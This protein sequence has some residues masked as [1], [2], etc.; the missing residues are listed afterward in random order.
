LGGTG[1]IRKNGTGTLTLSN[2]NYF[3]GG[4]TVSIGALVATNNTPQASNGIIT[5]GDANTAR[6]ITNLTSGYSVGGAFASNIVVNAQNAVFRHNLA[7]GSANLG[8]SARS[9]TL[10]ANTN[11]T[12]EAPGL[13]SNTALNY[14][15]AIKGSGTLTVGNTGTGRLA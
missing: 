1:G 12:F 3:N 4:I 6:N 5:L 10:N 14:Y 7:S 8:T 11:T 15:Q 13:A 9:I 2:A